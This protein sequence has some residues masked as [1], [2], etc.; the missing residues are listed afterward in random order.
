MYRAPNKREAKR[1]A[2]EFAWHALESGLACWDV[3]AELEDD[4]R[5]R[6]IAAFKELIEELQRRGTT[7]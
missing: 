3:F 7:Q 5:R 2:C 6:L 4:E 1:T